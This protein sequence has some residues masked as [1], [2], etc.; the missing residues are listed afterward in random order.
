MP[1]RRRL[2]VALALSAIVPGLGQ[3]YNKEAGKGL[4]IIGACL[5]LGLLIYL[6]AGMNYPAASC[7]VSKTRTKRVRSKLRGIN[8]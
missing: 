3:L 2:L 5:G 6:Q 4:A 7:G 1:D 8:P